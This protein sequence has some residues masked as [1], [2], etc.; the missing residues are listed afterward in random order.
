MSTVTLV[1]ELMVRLEYLHSER[2]MKKVRGLGYGKEIMV[3]L[4]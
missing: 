4:D 3:G 2:E 1:V